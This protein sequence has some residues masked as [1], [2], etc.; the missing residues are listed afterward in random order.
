MKPLILALISVFSIF[1]VSLAKSYLTQEEL[2]QDLSY[3]FKQVDS[4][5]SY[6][7]LTPLDLFLEKKRLVNELIGKDKIKVDDL[8]I[9]IQSFLAQ[10]IDAHAGISSFHQYFKHASKSDKLYLPFLIESINDDKEVQYIA[11]RED[12][13][14]FWDKDYPYILSINNVAISKYREKLSQYITGKSPRAISII[15]Q[16]DF[17]RR[18]GNMAYYLFFNKKFD[19]DF[20]QAT[21][22]NEK[23]ET[24]TGKIFLASK[25]PFYGEW[26]RKKTGI[27]DNKIGYLRLA[28]M[29]KMDG[30]N[31][32]KLHKQMHYFKDTQ[33]LII[34]VRGNGGGRRDILN[35]LLPYFMPEK[36]PY[37]VAA[38]GRCRLFLGCE[39]GSR[40]MHTLN[41]GFFSN[42][43]KKHI[44]AFMK[45]F[46]PE[47][48]YEQNKFSPWH[49]HFIRNQK[50]HHFYYNK[51]VIILM[52][53]EC[54]SATEVFL[55][56]FKERDNIILMGE[57]TFGG[58]AARLQYVLPHSK[59]EF[60]MGRM[61]SLQ[62]NG[63]LFDEQGVSP[64][65]KIISEKG[66][67]IGQ[68][69]QVL[70]NALKLL[71]D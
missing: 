22:V 31:A 4:K 11:I 51:K 58:S 38:L 66:Y 29:P 16:R 35:E 68:S 47:I 19:Q 54:F 30:V 24:K 26:P 7:Q 49:Y 56:A 27:I 67:F 70:E 2:E 52:D 34:D 69:D 1:S 53:K 41:S 14:N 28:K 21:F 57:K 39:I 3:F 15:L 20:V 62:R 37:Y 17:L 6:Y 42:N 65:I 5:F 59:I 60:S 43:E 12:R 25:R 44:K 10:F 8:A 9:C 48:K 55:S 40:W 45:K 61:L 18:Y 64:D 71:N 46:K 23:G 32:N 50:K 36:E 63:Q 13:K 33:G